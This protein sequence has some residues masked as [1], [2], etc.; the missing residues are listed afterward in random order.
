MWDLAVAICILTVAQA[1]DRITWM[2]VCE[3]VLVM[4]HVHRVA[5]FT[6]F[7]SSVLGA[8]VKQKTDALEH[9]WW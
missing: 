2:I 4:F 3:S 6:Q 9:Q 8:P 5:P 1:P 7:R